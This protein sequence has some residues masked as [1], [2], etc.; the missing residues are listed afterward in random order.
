MFCYVFF[1]M[2]LPWSIYRRPGF[3]FCSSWPPSGPPAPCEENS[4]VRKDDGDNLEN[5]SAHSAFG[6]KLAASPP[7]SLVEQKSEQTGGQSHQ[8]HGQHQPLPPAAFNAV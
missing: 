7:L 2:H 8:Q 5:L 6:L 4:G 3:L 1:G